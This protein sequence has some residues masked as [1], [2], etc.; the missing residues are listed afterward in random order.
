MSTGGTTIANS[1]LPTI[2]ASG[3]KT[4][5]GR[6]VPLHLLV[7]RP[8]SAIAVRCGPPHHDRQPPLADSTIV[9][10]HG[11]SPTH[12]RRCHRV[13]ARASEI[14]PHWPLHSSFTRLPPV[15]APSTI[16]I[17]TVPAAASSPRLSPLLLLAP[18]VHAFYVSAF[19]ETPLVRPR[20]REHALRALAFG[21]LVS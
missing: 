11:P 7:A 15:G 3:V 16:D 5:F 20:C 14:S 8:H 2:A 19:A 12:H 1:Q 21:G 13:A 4:R 6:L 9:S 17:H 10:P 18:N